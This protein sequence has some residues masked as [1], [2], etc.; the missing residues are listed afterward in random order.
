MIVRPGHC[1]ARW[2][3]NGCETRRLLNQCGQV[4]P[5]GATVEI[6]TDVGALRRQGQRDELDLE[7]SR[8]TAPCNRRGVPLTRVVGIR[9]HDDAIDAGRDELL[10]VRRFPLPGPA[11][12]AG[13][14]QAEIPEAVDIFFALGH[15][16]RL[17]SLEVGQSIQQWPETLG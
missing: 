5:G 4:V 15:E 6:V 1:R 14:R 17:A 8:D 12:V 3:G 16:H 9:D 7:A 2:R 10:R 13:R 11:V